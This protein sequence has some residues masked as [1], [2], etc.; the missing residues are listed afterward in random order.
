M[1]RFDGALLI[2]DTSCPV[3]LV[4]DLDCRQAGDVRFAPCWR[5]LRA[6]RLA[7][8]R[9][10]VAVELAAVGLSWR[11]AIRKLIGIL[12]SWPPGATSTTAFRACP[13]VQCV[14]LGCGLCAQ[15]R[16]L[17][18]VRKVTVGGRFGAIAG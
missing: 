10:A 16:W 3:C 9:L 15:G 5:A 1:R 12:A 18:W 2:E 6:C 14:R 4:G 8:F 11:S 13:R 17:G 7:A